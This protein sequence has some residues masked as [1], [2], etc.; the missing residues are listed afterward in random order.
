MPTERIGQEPGQSHVDDPQMSK[1]VADYF[2]KLGVSSDHLVV[3]CGGVE[4][5]TGHR[6][7]VIHVRFLPLW[8][9]SANNAQKIYLTIEHSEE[10]PVI[11][12][13]ERKLIAWAMDRLYET[14]PMAHAEWVQNRNRE[15]PAGL[16]IPEYHNVGANVQRV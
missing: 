1:F 12:R 14:L 8:M 13:S 2:Q 4:D 6:K 10:D 5:A 9:S 16:P 15:W 7:Y 11:Y 3:Q